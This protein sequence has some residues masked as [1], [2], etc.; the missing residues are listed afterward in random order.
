VAGL[1][2]INSKVKGNSL[3]HLS[4]GFLIPSAVVT[5]LG[6]V[7]EEG[8]SQGHVAGLS[9]MPCAYPR[10]GTQLLLQLT[11]HSPT[12]SP[13]L[14]FLIWLYSPCLVPLHILFCLPGM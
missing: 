8:G 12:E 14:F 4:L 11:P 1:P 5:K 10:A 9:A 3:L 13:P 7:C 6:V 2:Q